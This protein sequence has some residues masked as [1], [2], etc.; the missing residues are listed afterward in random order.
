[1][2]I[3]DYMDCYRTGPETLG[4]HYMR[5]F[6]HP[7]LP[8]RRL[9]AGLGQ[10]D[11]IMSEDFT[12]YRGE[13]GRAQVVAFQCAHRGSQLSVGWVEDDCIRCRYH[14]WKYD[15]TGQCIEGRGEGTRRKGA[16]PQLSHGKSTSDLSSFISA[17]ATPPLAAALSGFRK[18]RHS[19]SRL[20]SRAVQF[21]LQ[22]RNRSGAYSFRS[23]R[24][25]IFPTTSRARFPGCHRKKPNGASC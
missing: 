22:L 11:Q 12:L 8:R 15:A 7:V 4:G 10:A 20:T 14:G 19:G 25:G 13:G 23:P 18:R 3:I 1:M 24:I 5:L 17:P 2:P 16:H 21:S 9:E 6:W